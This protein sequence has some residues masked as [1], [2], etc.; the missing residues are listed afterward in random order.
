MGK[1]QSRITQVPRKDNL[2]ILRTFSKW[3]GLAGLRIG[4][5]AFPGWLMPTLW[6]AR[7]PYN[8]NCAA[9]AAALASLRDL[10]ILAE[11][12]GMIQSERKRIIESISRMPNITPYPSQANLLLCR[13]TNRNAADIQKYL[14]AQGILIRY[15]GVGR[16]EDNNRLLQAL[17]KEL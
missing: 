8:V 5:G 4:F 12:V 17:E 7:L 6:K 16:P 15:F 13:V 2:A 3:A 9:E 14:A 10:D 1:L 11:R